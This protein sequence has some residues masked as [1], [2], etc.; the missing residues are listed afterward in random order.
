MRTELAAVCFLTDERFLDLFFGDQ[1]LA[2]EDFIE[3]NWEAALKE[4][5]EQVQAA[6]EDRLTEF[7]EDMTLHLALREVGLAV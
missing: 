4:F 2:N 6:I 5:S 3:A 7:M 1:S